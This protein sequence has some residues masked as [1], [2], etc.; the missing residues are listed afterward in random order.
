MNVLL[1]RCESSVWKPFQSSLL[2]NYG[3]QC[4][5]SAGL[6]PTQTWQGSTGLIQS[7]SLVSTYTDQSEPHTYILLGWPHVVYKFYWLKVLN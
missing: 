2:K 6:H 5:S 4:G 1:T 3:A 7:S